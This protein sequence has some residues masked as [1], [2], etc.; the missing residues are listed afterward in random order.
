M[1]QLQFTPE[2][3]QAL[4][5]M[6]Y[7]GNRVIN[8]HR[9]EQ[10][11]KYSKI[12]ELLLAEALKAGLENCVDEESPDCA[13][14]EFEEGMLREYI[15][16]HDE[17]VFWEELIKYLTTIKMSEKFTAEQIAEMSQEDYFDHFFAL[18]QDVMEHL[19]NED[20]LSKILK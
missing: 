6:T 15:V 10:I 11:E 3:M 5:E 16:E 13:S 19:Q 9:E 18:E 20:A 4:L 1:I 17:N 8:G 12:Q 2:Q 14:E 7:L